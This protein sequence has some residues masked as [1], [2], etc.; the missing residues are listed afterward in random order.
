MN[1]TTFPVSTTN[2]FPIANSSTGGQLAT[3]FNLRSR[4]SVATDPAVKY[5]IGPS[6]A[7]SMDDYSVSCQLDSLGQAISTSV[8]QISPGKA[9]VN[10]HYVESL[11]PMIVDMNQANLD[12]RTLDQPVLKGQLTVGIRVNYSTV[13]TMAGSLL[14]E[15]S[16]DMFDG[17]QLVILP[18]DGEVGEKFTLPED[19]P[20]DPYK[21]NAHLK[22][23]DFTFIN[24]VIANIVQ[25]TKKVEYLDAIRIGNIDSIVSDEYATKPNLNAKNL[26]VMSGDGNWCSA[27]DSLI[28]WDSDPS[29][30]LTDGTLPPTHIGVA[31][32]EYDSVSGK[33]SLVLP[34]KQIDGMQNTSGQPQYFADVSAD[35]PLA[36]YSRGIGGT[37]DNNF[38]R[39]IKSIESQVN[40]LYTIRAGSLRQYL[41]DLDDRAD[42]P[43]IGSGWSAGDYVLVGIDNTFDS[44]TDRSPSTMYVVLPGLVT[45]YST[46]ATETQ[47]AGTQV[48]MTSLT[49]TGWASTDK[50]TLFDLTNSEYRGVP[51]SDY[52]LVNVYADDSDT[53]THRYY[54]VVTSSGGLEYAGVA[55]GTEPVW[56]TG[57][58][59]LASESAIGGFYNVPESATGYG[60]VYRDENGFLRILDWNLL[61]TGVLAYQL[62]DDVTVPSSLT[63]DEMQLYLE[64]Y[65]N[66]RVAFRTDTFDSADN[67]YVVNVNCTIP[68]ESEGSQVIV[69]R[70]IDSRFGTSVY[71]HLVGSGLTSNT[72]IMIDNCEKI[73][74]DLSGLS[75]SPIVSLTNCGLY[76]D[77]NVIDQLSVISG[78]KLWYEKFDADDLDLT[79]DGMTIELMGAPDRISTE[80]YWS[81]DTP[82]DNHFS[83]ALSSLTLGNDGK[84]I[85]FGLLVTDDMTANVSLGTYVHTAQFVLPQTFGLPYPRTA[86]TNKLKVSGNFITAYPTP[87][88]NPD[89]YIIKN[90][91]FTALTQEYN[92]D[93]SI[94]YTSGTI[95]FCTTAS[96]VA[97]VSGISGYPS[98]DGW[99][100]GKFHVFY[101]G[102]VGQ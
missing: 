31:H 66:N 91:S 49:E 82:N 43:P 83:Y 100:S 28:V 59:P 63:A 24:G 58:I 73:R 29:G 72:T 56:I 97:T 38:I 98:I 41:S 21:V 36:D 61:I 9:V 51:T 5:F 92:M 69:I 40:S 39:S 48:G 71:L 101:G 64:D 93:E 33:T 27:E 67:P 34:H 88:S 10:G 80:D 25:N 77:P 42:L 2:I 15:N 79:V 78:M 96:Q 14:I 16:N 55:P 85:K 95:S 57:R 6:F 18:K 62:G 99:E 87:S 86:M 45:A 13:P 37:V 4:E 47:P 81:A 17:V 74:L 20:D 44:G 50:S 46:S 30:H 84:A 32:F 8:L 35:L 26:Y 52:F 3:E 102:K 1:F 7:H 54:L 94:G 53:I 75:G 65:V 11:V 90:T 22:L 70:N 12:L 60:Y 89:S 23:A 76:Y 68:A 19:S